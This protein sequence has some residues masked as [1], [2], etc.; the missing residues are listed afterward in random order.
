MR[1]SLLS[2][3]SVMA[4]AACTTAGPATG[5]ESADSPSRSASFVVVGDTGYIPSYERFDDDEGPMK[6]IGE[7]MALMQEDWLERNPDMEGFRPTPWVF[8]SALGSYMEASGMWPVARAAD[9]ICRRDGCDFA[10]MVGDNIYPDGA[11]LGADGISDER[12]FQDMLNAP[13]GKLGEGVENFTI[14]TMMGN[15]DWHI[16]RAATEA[17]LKYLQDH[18]NFTMPDYFYSAVPAGMD[19]FVEIFVIDTEMLLA[20]TTVYEDNLDSQGREARTEELDTWPDFVA[21]QT[22]AEKNMVGWLRDSLAASDAKWKI[23]MGHHAVWSGGG[24]KFEKAHSLRAL[25]MDALCDYADVYISG[26]DHMTEVYSDTCNMDDRPELPTLVAGA[27]SK[28]RPLHKLFHANQLAN[29]PNLKN[30]YS[31][32]SDWGF[33]KLDL[34]EDQLLVNIY[35]AGTDMEGRPIDEGQVS[36]ERRSQFAK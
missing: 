6:T 8:E 15:H 4:L 31:R 22:E 9:E 21:P 23:V 36:F 35:S 27:G 24:S 25:Y 11:T 26:D 28:Y 16:S 20:S 10:A 14:Y 33:L 7:Y 29:N 32:G 19:G 34:T 30:Y 2:L 3:A 5:Q 18:P 13:Y 17:Q 12:R 1:R